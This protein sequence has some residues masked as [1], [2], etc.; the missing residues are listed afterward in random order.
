MDSRYVHIYLYNLKVFKII[1]DEV[2]ILHVADTRATIRN[3]QL[4]KNTTSL[5]RELGARTS[6][7]MGLV[8]YAA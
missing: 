7:A 5:N 6:S 4:S 3:R 2:E 1:G 8:L